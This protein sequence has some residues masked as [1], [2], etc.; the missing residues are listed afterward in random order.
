MNF[1]SQLSKQIKKT[2]K[3]KKRKLVGS[4]VNKDGLELTKDVYGNKK[5]RLE[6]GVEDRGDG[7]ASEHN[8][9]STTGSTTNTTVPYQENIDNS[10]NDNCH[11]T[12]THPVTTHPVTTHPV[13]TNPVTI[14]DDDLKLKLQHFNHKY[15]PLDKP[16]AIKTLASLIKQ[17]KYNRKQARY[18]AQRHREANTDPEINIDDI[19]TPQTYDN[20]KVQVRI[21][22][23][24][25]VNKWDQL[26][27]D[28]EKSLVHE[29]KLDLVLLLYK[30]R[31]D[32]Q[33][34]NSMIVS[35]AT[36]C[37]YLQ[38]QNYRKASESYMKLS[39]GNVAWPIGVMNVGIHERSKSVKTMGKRSNDETFDANIMIDDKTRKWIVGIKR[40]ITM[41]EKNRL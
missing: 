4:D 28:N 36:I 5:I 26:A 16:N 6:G 29:T 14:S 23:K 24:R 15:D 37:Y 35:L 32:D 8:A 1:S 13:T 17:E 27:T 7:V 31:T 30:L 20:L 22:I 34:T 39:L 40:L 38:T 9:S 11:K 25:L 19:T 2:K 21:Y 18:Q 12:S 33:L 3:D 41:C 10:N